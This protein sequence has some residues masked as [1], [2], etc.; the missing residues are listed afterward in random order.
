MVRHLL[1]TK[2]KNDATVHTAIPVH[3][4]LNGNPAAESYAVWRIGHGRF[5]ACACV[6]WAIGSGQIHNVMC[7]NVLIKGESRNS[8]RPINFKNVFRVRLSRAFL[9]DSDALILNVWPDFEKSVLLKLQMGWTFL[10]I[11][12]AF[13]PRCVDKNHLNVF[14]MCCGENM[15]YW[16]QPGI[17][18][19]SQLL[20]MAHK[21][22]FWLP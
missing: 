15:V 16:L 19:S 9:V 20:W 10:A 2:K 1:V 4:G 17:K 8:H 5:V 13:L 11:F 21:L 14:V 7:R 3:T 22:I 18:T 12:L 6:C